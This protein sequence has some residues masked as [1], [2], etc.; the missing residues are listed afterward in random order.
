MANIDLNKLNGDLR[1]IHEAS[2]E[3]LSRTGMRILQPEAVEILAAEGFS[4]EGD[5]VRFDGDKLM[6]LVERAP[7]SFRMYGRDPECVIEVGGDNIEPAPAYGAP[8]IAE[9]DGKVR[10]A[11][12]DDYRELVRLH[13]QSGLYKVNGGLPVHPA[14]VCVERLLYES[15]L[16]TDKVLMTG[17]GDRATAANLMAMLGIVFGSKEDLIAKPRVL[18]IININSPLVFDTNMVDSMI[19]FVS[20]GQPV[21]ITAGG[22]PGASTP[23]TQAGNQAMA[24]AERLMG[25]ALA[26][27]VRP[28]A[29]VMFGVM[30]CTMD[31]RRGALAYGGPESV[32]ALKMGKAL[33][34]AYGLPT[35]G[36]GA[37]TDAFSPGAQAAY[38]SMLTLLTSCNL[39]LNLI[40]H[41]AGVLDGIKSISYEKMMIDFEMLGIALESIQPP[42][43]DEERLAL[44][45][46]DRVGPGGNYLVE[47]ETIKYCRKE[48]HMTDL[49]L[50][51]SASGD[52][53]VEY[54]ARIMNRLE[55]LLGAYRQPEFDPA[56]DQ[57]LRDFL[58][59]KGIGTE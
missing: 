23:M 55:D 18:T 21:A 53:E 45:S 17:N 26:Q 54:T 24:N 20:H 58:A 9:A 29:P 4:V 39:G 12:L 11:E 50:R 48:V 19:E 5:L 3:V 16:L 32:K 27:A 41:T 15:L 57:A 43:V 47:P 51:G 49:A 22:M 1:R 59:G 33:A 6:A 14:G 34:E 56:V 38:E 44:E 40:I 36:G 7:A 35:R 8:F 10:D 31:M 30:G 42:V 25:I 28:G 46:M 2:L 52:P 37:L 13:H